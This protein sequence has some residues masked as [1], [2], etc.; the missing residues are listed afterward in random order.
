MEGAG[1]TRTSGGYAKLQLSGEIIYFGG[2]F[3]WSVFE[4]TNPLM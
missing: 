3:K 4:Y 1:H 2:G